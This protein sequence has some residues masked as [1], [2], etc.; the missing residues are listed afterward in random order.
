MTVLDRKSM[1]FPHSNDATFEEKINALVE[2]L[3][4]TTGVAG[5]HDCPTGDM[6]IAREL[7]KLIPELFDKIAH[8]EQGHRDWLEE[9]IQNHFQGKPMPEYRVK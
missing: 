2:G 5:S 7:I 6:E 3:E 1:L 9:A 8:G 4:Y